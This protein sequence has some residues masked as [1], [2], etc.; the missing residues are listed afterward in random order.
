MFGMS[1]TVEEWLARDGR[2]R[3]D[4]DLA[5]VTELWSIIGLGDGARADFRKKS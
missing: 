2:H 5:Q 4:L 1:G 3:I